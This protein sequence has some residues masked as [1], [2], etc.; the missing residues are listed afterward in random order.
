MTDGRLIVKLHVHL[1]KAC[2]PC[3]GSSY[4]V[5]AHSLLMTTCSEHPPTDCEHGIALGRERDLS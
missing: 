4:T 2:C 3:C 5:R 1:D